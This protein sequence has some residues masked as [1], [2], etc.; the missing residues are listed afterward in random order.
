MSYTKNCSPPPASA[1][2]SSTSGPWAW[3]RAVSPPTSPPTPQSP[4]RPHDAASHLP[5]AP[6]MLLR[7][8]P[9]QSLVP[10]QT[11]KPEANFLPRSMATF[12]AACVP[13]SLPLSC[14][15]LILQGEAG[16]QVRRSLQK[17]RPGTR[18]LERGQRAQG[19]GWGGRVTNG[20]SREGGAPRYRKALTLNGHRTQ[21]HELPKGQEARRGGRG[22][23]VF[24]KLSLRRWRDF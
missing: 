14:E 17:R 13:M 8:C 12:G 1:P 4:L 18:G 22:R 5:A 10:S 11:P 6:T 23:M 21:C 16:G 20:A 19:W 3:P 9:S 7:P 2:S 15:E 24:C